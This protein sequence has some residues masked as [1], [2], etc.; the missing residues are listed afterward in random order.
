M[1][2]NNTKNNETQSNKNEIQNQNQINNERDTIQLFLKNLWNNR[3]IQI[4][5]NMFKEYESKKDLNE[6]NYIFNSIINYCLMK[7]SKLNT[8]LEEKSSILK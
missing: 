8:F 2:N 3:E 6:K 5:I 7:E 4:I 1:G